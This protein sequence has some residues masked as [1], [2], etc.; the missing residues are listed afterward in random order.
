MLWLSGEHRGDGTDHGCQCRGALCPLFPSTAYPCSLGISRCDSILCRILYGILLIF[1]FRNLPQPLPNKY[2]YL[3]VSMMYWIVVCP[4][5]D[6]HENQRQQPNIQP[7]SQC[8]CTG[9]Q[10]QRGQEE[11]R[12]SP[13]QHGQGG[14]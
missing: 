5:S 1:Y 4:N 9:R 14:A 3:Y 7:H 6:R 11:W 8:H 2:L 10:V 13:H 12:T